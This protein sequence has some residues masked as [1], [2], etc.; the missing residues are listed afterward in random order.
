MTALDLL[1][2]ISH[3]LNCSP[4]P[5]FGSAGGMSAS[6]GHSTVVRF[7]VWQRQLDAN[8]CNGDAS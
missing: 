7:L 1:K 6:R 4:M 8:I 3:A 2:P 5:C